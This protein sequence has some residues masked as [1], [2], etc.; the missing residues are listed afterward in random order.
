MINLGR[1]IVFLLGRYE[2]IPVAGLGTFSSSNEPSS[3]DETAG[4]YQ[5]GKRTVTFEA[6]AGTGQYDQIL[7]DFIAAQ[8]NVDRPEAQ[9]IFRKAITKLLHELEN[10]G[11][12]DLDGLGT[13][14]LKG[15][16]MEFVPLAQDSDPLSNTEGVLK[17]APIVVVEE[18]Q[19]PQEEL[20]VEAANF[21]PEE[22]ADESNG[23]GGFW[24]GLLIGVL[25]LALVGLGIFYLRPDLVENLTSRFATGQQQE[26]STLV[27]QL[28]I[29][30]D[31]APEG[32]ILV[33]DSLDFSDEEV[34]DESLPIGA[35]EIAE[36]V[37]P[38][39]TYEIVVG[40]FATMEQAEK[41]VE[42]MKN[43]GISV[44]AIDSRM[45]GNRKKVSY[46]SYASEAEAYRALPEVQKTVE[47]T[48][49]VARVQR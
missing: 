28:A 40:S 19:V 14:L 8:R 12:V 3:F 6:D 41:F 25:L 16:E 46:G 11:S 23:S 33:L 9:S 18:V 30:E 15:N 49:W 26:Q 17:P 37:A 1:S 22:E 42:Q 39:A 38:K 36:T 20:P 5:L 29:E 4:V 43:K 7:L 31:P 10:K 24:K 13:I 2:R 45:P 44:Q 21:M 27:D 47:P 35:P 32:E 48:A 34:M